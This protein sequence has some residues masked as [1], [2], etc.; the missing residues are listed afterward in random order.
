MDS[1]E[2]DQFENEL[3]EYRDEQ[4]AFVTCNRIDFNGWS[5]KQLGSAFSDLEERGSVEAVSY[6]SCT[7]WKI[8]LD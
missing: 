6:S 7:T 1:E 2:L 3:R 5:N 8:T 4:G